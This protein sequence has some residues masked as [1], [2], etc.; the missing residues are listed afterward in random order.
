MCRQLAVVRTQAR[1][2]CQ[3]TL[4]CQIERLFTT[5]QRNATRREVLPGEVREGFVGVGHFVCVF[6]LGDRGP[7]AIVSR[8]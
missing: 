8:E 2:H 4:R 7:F 3:V 6:A 1:L 5:E